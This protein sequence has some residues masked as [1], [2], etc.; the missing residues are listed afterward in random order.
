MMRATTTTT[1][2]IVALVNRG[3]AE[4]GFEDAAAKKEAVVFENDW[5]GE[6]GDRKGY[7][8]P[9]TCREERLALRRRERDRGALRISRREEEAPKAKTTTSKEEVR[10]RML[11]CRTCN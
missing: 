1:T 4:R 9:E 3:F 8:T 6:K 5:S 11:S 10:R 2:S 7:F